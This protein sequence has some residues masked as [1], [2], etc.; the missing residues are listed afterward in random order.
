MSLIVR[1]EVDVEYVAEGIFTEI[2]LRD[3]GSLGKWT[4]CR[5]HLQRFH[6]GEHILC[7]LRAVIYKQIFPVVFYGLLFWQLNIRITTE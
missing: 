2:H 7:I 5:R 6:R 4:Q 3:P 1:L